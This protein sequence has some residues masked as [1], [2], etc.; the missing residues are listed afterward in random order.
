MKREDVDAF[1]AART[2]GWSVRQIAPLVGLSKSAVH[3]HIQSMRAAG[4][5]PGR[6]E[7]PPARK[8]PDTGG[9]Q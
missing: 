1:I 4:I 7:L 9:G 3:R 8:R 6:D 2:P 5:M